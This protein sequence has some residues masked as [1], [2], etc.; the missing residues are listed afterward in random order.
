MKNVLIPFNFSR[1]SIN[2]LDYAIEF[3]TKEPSIS[4]YLLYIYEDDI[5]QEEIQNKL[6]K[7]ISKYRDPLVAKIKTIVRKG[8]LIPSVL[9]LQEEL[10]IDLVL[11]GTKGAE[12]G[13]VGIATRTSKFVKEANLPVLVIPEK[14]RNFQLKKIILTLG[15]EKIADKDAL[16]TLLD[17][18]RRFG[19]E[20]HILTINKDKTSIGYSEEDESNENTLQYFLEMFYS[21]RS[22]LENE[23]IEKGIM[24][25]LDTHEADMLAIMPNTHLENGNASEGELTRILTLHTQTPLLVLD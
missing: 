9:N 11:M 7:V 23:D 5:N 15:R 1:A 13:E 14:A 17:V 24:E 6:A 22:F 19:A 18:S 10:G 3:T 16:Y 4:L 25:Y 21:H 2:A 12:I 8:K 20:V